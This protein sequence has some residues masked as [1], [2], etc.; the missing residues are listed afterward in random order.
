MG[1]G[2]SRK[3]FHGII[4][5]LDLYRIAV[6]SFPK[7]KFFAGSV[8]RGQGNLGIV[9]DYELQEYFHMIFGLRREA[10]KEE[11]R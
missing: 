3:N 9:P 7:R 11:G 6:I 8:A 2:S 10:M 5:S 1:F 4:R